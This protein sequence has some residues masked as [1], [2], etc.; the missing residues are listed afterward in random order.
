VLNIRVIFIFRSLRL[1]LTLLSLLGKYD[2]N[3]TSSAR[4]DQPGNGIIRHVA[5][6]LS[7]ATR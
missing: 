7:A 6:A 1:V 5:M 4:R 3:V 2:A